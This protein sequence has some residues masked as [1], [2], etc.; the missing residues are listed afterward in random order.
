MARS[1]ASRVG[2]PTVALLLLV[3]PL[4]ARAGTADVVEVEV[5]CQERIC[6]FDV[7]VRHDDTG[8]SHYADRFEVLAPDGSSLGTRVLRHPH[9]NEQPFT[10]AIE[11]VRVPESVKEVRIR[12]RDSEHGWGGAEVTLPIP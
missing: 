9:V 1:F 6:R 7:S 10:R 11:G 4:P 12:A 8:W 3:A 5:K 2:T